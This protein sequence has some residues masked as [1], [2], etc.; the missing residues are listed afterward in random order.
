MSDPKG[1]KIITASTLFERLTSTQ[2]PVTSHTW[3]DFNRLSNKTKKDFAKGL[4]AAYKMA[5][6]CAEA[7]METSAH[8]TTKSSEGQSFLKKWSAFG[9]MFDSTKA[10]QVAQAA[11]L[12]NHVI[13]I[14]LADACRDVIYMEGVLG[15]A[16]TVVPGAN[17]ESDMPNGVK[18]N[19]ESVDELATETVGFEVT[20][21]GIGEQGDDWEWPEDVF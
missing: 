12:P 14:L 16:A 9:S 7:L 1:G 6:S 4:E 2:H 21:N 8:D 11:Q 20:A 15:I 18:P 10:A 5:M 17:G 19:F 13:C 3:E